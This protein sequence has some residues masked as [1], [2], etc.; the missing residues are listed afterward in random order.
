M[1]QDTM[2]AR[3]HMAMAALNGI[4]ANEG[5]MAWHAVVPVA[6]KIADAMMEARTKPDD[7]TS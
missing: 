5:R 3:D 6:Y 1:D 2:T 4:L 7:K